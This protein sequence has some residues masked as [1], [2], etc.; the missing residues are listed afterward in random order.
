MKSDEQIIEELYLSAFSRFPTS[1]EIALMRQAFDEVPDPTASS[2]SALDRDNARRRAAT[3][4]VL[5]TLINT[6]EFIYNH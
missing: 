6:K 5:W 1:Q 2:G 4:D 3:E